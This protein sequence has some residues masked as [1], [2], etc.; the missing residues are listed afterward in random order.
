MDEMWTP[1][2]RRADAA[3]CWF[4]WCSQPRCSESNEKVGS[5]RCSRVGYQLLMCTRTCS[6]YF[7]YVYHW[8]RG[9]YAQKF[10]KFPGKSFAVGYIKVV[11]GKC[12]MRSICLKKKLAVNDIRKSMRI[13]SCSK[14]IYFDIEWIFKIFFK[15]RLIRCKSWSSVM[16]EVNQISIIVDQRSKVNFVFMNE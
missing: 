2:F 5:L 15:L 16:E 10:R 14:Y 13:L 7:R 11:L 3:N 12:N 9:W 6:I 8:N 1:S 4:L